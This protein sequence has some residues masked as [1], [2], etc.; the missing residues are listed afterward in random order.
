MDTTEQLTGL[1]IPQKN[2]GFA[3][4]ALENMENFASNIN[5]EQIFCNHHLHTEPL[6][7]HNSLQCVK[8]KPVVANSFGVVSPVLHRSV[9]FGKKP[10]GTKHT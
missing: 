6:K 8:S 10:R 9:G 1:G 4:R 2:H 3:L 7:G 5:I